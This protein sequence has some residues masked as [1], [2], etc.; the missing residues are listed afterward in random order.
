[1]RQRSIVSLI[2]ASNLLVVSGM[3][4]PRYTVTDLGIIGPSTTVAPV[5]PFGITNR[6]LIAGGAFVGDDEHAV[7]WYLGRRFDLG[8]LSGGLNSIGLALNQSG[9]VVGISE[10]GTVDPNDEDFCGFQ[11]DGL[12]SHGGACLPFLWQNGVMRAFPTLGGTNGVAIGTNSFG[13]VAGWAE[14]ALAASDCPGTQKLQFKPVIWRNGNIQELPT[15]AGDDVGGAYFITDSGTIVGSSGKCG[16]FNGN[17]F[18][19]L[20]PLHAVVWQDGK[21]MDIG[22][23]GGTGQGTG[24]LP[25]AANNRGQVVGGS[26][27]AGN[28]VSHAFVWTEQQGMKDLG[29]LPGDEDSFAI[30]INEA[31][32]I[33]GL[34]QAANFNIRAAIWHDGIASDLNDLIPGDSPLYLLLASAINSRGQIVGLAADVAG[35]LHGYVATPDGCNAQALDGHE[36]WTLSEEG[37]RILGTLPYVRF[38]PRRQE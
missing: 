37:R 30:Y 4:Q 19:N 1:M 10:T 15:L 16:T 34:S 38:V 5:Q 31:G 23:L 36:R 8:T 11:A 22:N 7:L 33:V 21:I 14:N 26:D 28:Q 2:F 29:T 25:V 24:N 27:L 35:N 18:A 9:Q 17:A 12:P 3:A 20:Q 13:D 6:G 32:Q